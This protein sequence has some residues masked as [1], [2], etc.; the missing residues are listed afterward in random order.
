MN[1]RQRI[2]ASVVFQKVDRVPYDF[3]DEAGDL[4]VEGGY[5]PAERLRLTYALKIKARVRFH[6]IYQT[7]LIFDTP[8]LIPSKVPHRVTLTYEGPPV[9]APEPLLSSI[10][11]MAWNAMP[12]CVLG[13]G[14]LPETTRG[15][16]VKHVAWAN[17]CS[18][19]EALDLDTG[20]S[21][22]LKPL[23]ASPADLL[24]HLDCVAGNLP[25]ADYTWTNQL[26]A[27]VGPD[28]MLSATLL[29]PF[30]AI[31]WYVGNEALMYLLYD[32]S[33]T[34]TQICDALLE[35]A[36]ATGRD[37]I[38]HGLDMFRIGAATSCLLSPDLYRQF[39]LPY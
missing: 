28:V 38:R 33:R 6:Q 16:V 10:S 18:S 5:R 20:T 21:D 11:G 17:G 37:M 29:D 25:R 32:D 19:S 9:I 27:Q 12:P 1:P 13:A 24:A 7:D 35:M 30:S 2:L 26:R 15:T 39:C 31:G 23:F 36:T 3:F 14:L 34:L 4:F 8:V 22:I